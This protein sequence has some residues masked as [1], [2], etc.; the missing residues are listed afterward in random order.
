MMD[1]GTILTL[2]AAA[3]LLV[4]ADAVIRQ[5]KLTAR[6]E[7]AGVTWFLICA[8]SHYTGMAWS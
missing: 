3:F 2:G 5:R 4:S 1:T 7:V 8:I 6:L